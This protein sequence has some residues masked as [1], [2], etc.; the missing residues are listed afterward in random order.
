MSY[1]V[2]VYDDSGAELYSEVVKVCLLSCVDTKPHV[3]A[4]AFL[5]GELVAPL[6]AGAVVAVNGLVN[7]LYSEIPGLSDLVTDCESFCTEREKVGDA[8]G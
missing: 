6:L 1:K 8:N 4:R 5:D 3:E 7:Q 2:C